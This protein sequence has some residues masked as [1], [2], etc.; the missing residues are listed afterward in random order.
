MN[1]AK[2]PEVEQTIETADRFLRYQQP[3]NKN[4]LFTF[5]LW[6][7]YFRVREGGG[8][9]IRPTI[10]YSKNWTEPIFLSLLPT[11]PLDHL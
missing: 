3:E 10:A 11:Q 8:V 6:N 4:E 9:G 2:P 5:H 7:M 1:E